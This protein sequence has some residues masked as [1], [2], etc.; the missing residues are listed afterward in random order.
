MYIIHNLENTVVQRAVRGRRD[1][2][3]RRRSATNWTR[4]S[5]FRHRE[6]LL[7]P[8]S[9]RTL[10]NGAGLLHATLTSCVLFYD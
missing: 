7:I 3:R 4:S 10:V 9:R 8:I 1:D 5:M 2:G 6:T